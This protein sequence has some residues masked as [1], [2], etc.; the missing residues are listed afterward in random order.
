MSTRTPANENQL[1]LLFDSVGY[2]YIRFSVEP[3]NCYRFLSIN[4][5][6]LDATGLPEDQIIGRQIDEVMPAP[7][8]ETAKGNF[9]KA[10]EE[11]RIISWGVATEYLS[12]I[13][14]C[15]S[16]AM[17]VFNEDGVCTQIVCLMK[18]MSDYRGAEIAQPRQSDR[19]Q[20]YLDIAGVILVALG[21][22]GTVTLIN[23]KGSEVLGYDQ[24]YIVGKNWFDTFLK[25]GDDVKVVFNDL[26]AGN[27]EPAEYHENTV[28]TKSGEERVV[29]WHNTC[30]KDENGNI[31]GTLSSGED[32]T[33]RRLAE[34][35]LRD[36][37]EIINRSPAVAFLWKNDVGWPVEFV[38]ENVLA[39]FGYTKDEFMSEEAT[40][41]STIHPDDIDRVSQEVFSH[42]TED[43]SRFTHEP[44]RIITKNGD[45]KW[46]ED[47]T[48]I[49]RNSEG[50]IT[51]Y[52]GIVV[53][54]SKRVKVATA[55]KESEEKLKQAQKLESIGRLA[56]G[57]AHDFNNLLT[58]II[59]YTDLISGE[60]YLSD[61]TADGIREIRTAANRAAALTQQLLAFSRK[62]VLQPQGI[63]LDRLINDLGNMLK[64]LIGENIDL[65]MHLCSSPK[66]IRADPGQIEQTIVNLV[67]NAKDALPDGGKIVLQ[68]QEI[69]LAEGEP[70]EHPEVAAGNYILLTVSDS[71]HGIDEEI[72]K[73][74]FEPFFTTKEVGR[75]TGL[76]LATGYGIVTQS[77]GHIF[78]HSQVGQGTSFVI[79]LPQFDGSIDQQTESGER[80]GLIRGDETILIVEDDES[81]R[82]MACSMLRGFGYS[83]IEAKNGM[84]ALEVA[85]RETRA[86]IDLL[87][88]DVIMPKMGGRVL[89][90]MLQAKYP[91]MKVLFISGHTDDMILHHGVLDENV[92]FLQKPFS[93]SL[94]A[95][96]VRKVLDE[97]T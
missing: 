75:G 21:A 37:Y 18:D 57:I 23:R 69:C 10:I 80:K 90:N 77:G 14:A 84:E 83:V 74:I 86:H 78:V 19:A 73:H 92:W 29:A 82:R 70:R 12:D 96:K 87:V 63:N 81:L 67:V 9:R 85:A 71:G 34:E 33:E 72:M 28:L 13:G 97:G 93:S 50:E 53:D 1:P 95:S 66:G 26:M 46:I 60:Q 91:H 47:T 52:E 55:L 43:L 62:Q 6:F 88:T 64:R 89:S 38:T 24:E 5:H 39:I 54:I 41:S 7:F 45:E 65:K 15:D 17:P 25:S 61:A 3:D 44:Y 35:T 30:L 40:Y 36:A 48:Y 4:R 31:I 79:Y 56:G 42:S 58:T 76:G 59:G 51:H 68:T 2:L 16:S 27:I 32:I 22:D 49:R 8:C 94:F 11:N 20:E